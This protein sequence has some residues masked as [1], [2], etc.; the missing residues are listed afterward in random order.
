MENIVRRAKEKQIELIGFA[1][2][3]H[4]GFNAPTIEEIGQARSFV[5][6]YQ[7]TLR[8]YLGIEAS[9]LDQSGRI[10][11]N[12]KEKTLFDYI[13]AS[14]HPNFPGVVKFPAANVRTFI[15]FL[16]R[17]YMNTA[18]NPLINVIGHPWNLHSK[19]VYDNTFS[20]YG[21]CKTL[22]ISPASCFEQIPDSYFEEFA[23][24]VRESEKAVELNVYGIATKETGALYGE[25]ETA[26]N[27]FGASYLRF[28][29]ILV[30]KGVKF[31]AG[32][33]AHSLKHVGDT[34]LL[35]RY[36]EMLGIG[37]DRLWHPF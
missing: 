33:D 4:P 5:R 31:T 17:L 29:H 11:L 28:Y 9:I 20:F 35:D 7:G 15:D 23:Q 19:S 25:D 1:D 36:F 18:V 12:K 34:R 3:Y 16:Q 6:S 27:E 22:G 30:Q 14:L 32:S 2:H 8:V 26:R 13:I 37:E 21:I 10:T 24:A